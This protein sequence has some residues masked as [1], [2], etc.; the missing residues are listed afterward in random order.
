MSNER[1][2]IPKSA[3]SGKFSQAN[4]EIKEEG[5]EA[6]SSASA[7]RGTQKGNEKRP[8]SEQG[9]AQ[10]QQELAPQDQWIGTLL[11]QVDNADKNANAAKVRAAVYM[12][13]KSN[14][15]STHNW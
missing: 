15:R 5:K 7:M 10:D 11:E 9:F 4:H 13:G 8:M 12:S 14:E 1:M 3:Q 2:D 6:S